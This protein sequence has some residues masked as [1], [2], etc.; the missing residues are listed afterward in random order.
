MTIRVVHLIEQWGSNKVSSYIF[1]FGA[2]AWHSLCCPQVFCLEPFSYCSFD[3]I[4]VTVIITYNCHF[5]S[6]PTRDFLSQISKNFGPQHFWPYVL[7]NSNFPAKI[8][9]FLCFIWIGNRCLIIKVIFKVSNIVGMDF[10]SK[11]SKSTN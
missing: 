2:K 5:V 9:P 1:L 4:I 8:W 6:P 10:Y 11:H 7:W 3:A